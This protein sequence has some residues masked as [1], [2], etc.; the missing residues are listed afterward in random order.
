MD[1]LN[2][3]NH[4]TPPGK[5]PD[6]E[7]GGGSS[8][9]T[10]GGERPDQRPSQYLPHGDLS[11][12]PVGSSAGSGSGAGAGPGAGQGAAGA[13]SQQIA[14]SPVSARVPERV[15]R[16][17]MT[18]GVIVLDSPNEFVLDFLQGL[19]RP[20]SIAA[21]VVLPPA[22]MFSF[23]NSVRDNLAKYTERFG[24]P[25]PLPKPPPQQPRPSI[26]ELYEHFK[27]P[28]DLMSGSYANS[29]LI[30]HSPSEFL[31]DFITGFYPTASVSSRVFLSAQQVPRTLETLTA[32]LGTYQKRFQPQAKPQQQQQPPAPG[33]NPRG[34]ESPTG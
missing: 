26:Q 34:P 16:G 17:V 28:E 3:P 31:F 14:H 25:A 8:G 18:T 24:P 29:V 19:S 21:R 32:A 11:G 30:G 10:P 23:V 2:D 15:A 33:Q 12:T 7:G 6:G 27:L 5:G 1:D 20:P 4:G 9:D 13:Y 22:V